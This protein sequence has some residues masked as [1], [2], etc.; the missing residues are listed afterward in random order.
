MAGLVLTLTGFALV[1]L[2]LPVDP[3]GAAHELPL[4]GA[5]I[6]AL[7]FGGILFGTVLRRRR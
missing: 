2:E 7:W 6:I 1:S 4:I 3:N 5:G